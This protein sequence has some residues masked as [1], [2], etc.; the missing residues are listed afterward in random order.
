MK[1]ETRILEVL[2][3]MS[4]EE[5]IG[6]LSLVNGAGGHIPES[7]RIAI[8]QGRVGAILNE[9]AAETI[10]ELQRIAVNESRLGI[11]LLI[12]R[13]VIHG[14]KTIF[15]IPLG[16]A[17]SWNPELVE[18]SARIAALEAASMGI[19]WTFAPMLDIG[20][21]PRWGRIA[22]TFG[23]DPYLAGII[24]K[25]MVKGYQGRNLAEPGNIAACA[26]HFA[27][28]GA[29]ESGR[30]YNTTNIPE[31]EL[32][33][34]HLPPFKAALDAGVV[35][36]MTA[37][38]DLN[39]IPASANDFL[40]QKILRD[41]WNF[42]GFVVSDY[43]SIPQLSV[44]GFTANDKES[45]CAAASAFVDMEMGSNTYADLTSYPHMR[46]SDT[47]QNSQ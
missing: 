6:Q 38:T 21:D 29:S 3:K 37:F 24:A 15:P 22:E 36:F 7:F 41:E 39:G 8:Q 1:E 31:N 11:P 23:E 16:L 28:Q 20:R 19:N 9:V 35:S 47:V 32:R 12:G 2:N 40:L 5:K 4:L 30:D 46:A 27:G 45:A 26:K 43:D 25:A 13:D 44:H 14:F 18:I 33:N 10:H 42:E 17:A 34:V